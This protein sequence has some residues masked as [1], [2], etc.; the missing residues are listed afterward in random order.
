MN[1]F[2]TVSL[3][4]VLE[5]RIPSDWGK[6]KIILIGFVG[7]SFQD[8][9]LTP[10]TNSPDQRMP[11]VEIHGHIISQIIDSAKGNQDSRTLIKT[12]SETK[13][14]LW[15]IFLDITRCDRDM[16]FA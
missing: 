5:N 15:I 10:Y 9:H 16:E 8:V 4:D 12:W 1:H 3:L 11:G 6:N 7:E 2:D 14:N 13:E